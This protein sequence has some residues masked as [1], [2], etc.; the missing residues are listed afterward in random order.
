[1]SHLWFWVDFDWPRKKRVCS[2]WLQQIAPIRTPNQEHVML[3]CK[4]YANRWPFQIV[5]MR[6]LLLPIGYRD[7]Q[8][9]ES[10]H[11]SNCETAKIKLPKPSIRSIRLLAG[12]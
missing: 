1:V 4:F 6:L 5:L 11:Q 12:L 3:W 8:T 10:L 7:C 9:D 2:D